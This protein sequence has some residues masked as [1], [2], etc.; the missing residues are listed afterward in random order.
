MAVGI[1][2][3]P[4][5]VKAKASESVKAKAREILKRL[6]VKKITASEAAYRRV[7]TP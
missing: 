1:S 6:N 2:A 5:S 3:S 7:K 4:E